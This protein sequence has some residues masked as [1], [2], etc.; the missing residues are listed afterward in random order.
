MLVMGT[1]Y[2]SARGVVGED[3]G[4]N[5]DVIGWDDGSI[6]G[7]DVGFDVVGGDVGFDVVGWDD[8][9]IVGADVGFDVVGWPK[10]VH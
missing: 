6:V 2:I 5:V 1:M 9:S 4:F 7:A 8:S 3:V 10:K